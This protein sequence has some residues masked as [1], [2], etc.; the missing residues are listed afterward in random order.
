[1]NSLH[2][3]NHLIYQCQC[4]FAKASALSFKAFCSGESN[5]D[6]EEVNRIEMLKSMLLANFAPEIRRGVITANP[7]TLD[8]IKEAALQERAWNSCR[9]P[10]RPFVQVKHLP[11]LFMPYY[12]AAEQVIR[13]SRKYVTGWQNKS[14]RWQRKWRILLNIQRRLHPRYL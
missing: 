8:E 3:N 11:T 4:F 2:F 7:K 9:T 6:T 5:K 13:V 14:K 10:P 12:L 1:M